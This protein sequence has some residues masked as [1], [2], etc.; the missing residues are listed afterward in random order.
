MTELF[1][2]PLVDLLADPD[3]YDD[4]ERRDRVGEGPTVSAEMRAALM[5]RPAY[6]GMLD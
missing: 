5:A 6:L 2:D 4:L 3:A 1:P